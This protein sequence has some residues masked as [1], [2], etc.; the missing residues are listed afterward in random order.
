MKNERFVDAYNRMLERVREVMGQEA[1]ALREAVDHAEEKAVELGELTREEAERIGDYLVRDLH[2][3]GEYMSKSGDELRDW[4]RFDL[5]KIEAQVLTLFADLADKTTVE[6][7]A[8]A[9]RARRAGER[10]TGQV[11]GIGTLECTGC[12]ERIHFEK[13]GHIPPCPK[14]HGTDYRRVE[15]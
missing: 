14:C 4:L 2:D 11:T 13:T 5:E 12:G 8:L 7:A 6:L 15:D 9:E 3:A 10:H 1:Q